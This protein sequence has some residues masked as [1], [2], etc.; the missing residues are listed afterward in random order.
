MQTHGAVA[1]AFGDQQGQLVW[2]RLG[3]SEQAAHL[4]ELGDLARHLFLEVGTVAAQLVRGTSRPCSNSSCQRSSTSLRRSSVGMSVLTERAW[5]NR[6]RS[7]NHTRKAECLTTQNEAR[8]GLV[9]AVG[10][11]GGSQDACH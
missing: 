8:F 9:Q 10:A 1:Q 2:R 6:T 7:S 5:G 11:G 3:G 4:L